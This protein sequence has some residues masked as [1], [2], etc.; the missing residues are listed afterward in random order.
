MIIKFYSKLS[1][2]LCLS[3]NTD[4]EREEKGIQIM[5]D[6]E[7]EHGISDTNYNKR[8]RKHIILSTSGS[9][10]LDR[11]SILLAFPFVLPDNFYY[12]NKPMNPSKKK[13]T[14]FNT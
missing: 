6:K 5:Q 2:V 11:T 4:Y 1:H 7:K 8:P 13:I 9:G 14:I 10:K 3:S 12:S